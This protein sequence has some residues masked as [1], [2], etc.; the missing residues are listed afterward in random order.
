ML[1][2]EIAKGLCRNQEFKVS[3]FLILR[4]LILK[5]GMVSIAI[6]LTL[7]LA[8]LALGIFVDLRWLV[9]FFMLTC[10]IAPMGIAFLYIFYALKPLYAFNTLPHTISIHGRRLTIRIYLPTSELNKNKEESEGGFPEGEENKGVENDEE[11]NKGEEN[12]EEKYKDMEIDLDDIGLPEMYG[13]AMYYPIAGKEGLLILPMLTDE[14]SS[15]H[16]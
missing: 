9:T 10:L 1:S 13:K 6:F 8:A 3:S 4:Y 15:T 16:Y 5:E 14:D 11:G 2:D 12:K 7:A